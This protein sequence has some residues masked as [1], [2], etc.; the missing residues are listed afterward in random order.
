MSAARRRSRRAGHAS[1]SPSSL[2]D[3]GRM[4]WS[5]A[6]TTSPVMPCGAMAASMSAM[7]LSVE[8]FS[9]AFEDLSVQLSA[10]AVSG[11]SLGIGCPPGAGLVQ[12]P[13]GSRVQR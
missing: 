1:P 5:A 10:K 3:A 13:G 2:R 9:F 12:R 7:S 11:G 6:R 4:S 8:L